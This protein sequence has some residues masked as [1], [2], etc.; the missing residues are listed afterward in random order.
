[1]PALG[2][3]CIWTLEIVVTI[4]VRLV[5]W[6]AIGA[7]AGV[8]LFYRGFRMLQFKRLVLN[9]PF[10]KIRSASMGLVEVSGMAVGP[11]TIQAGITGTPC[12]YYCATAWELKQ[13]GNNR[14]WK[15]V[16]E[17]TL[18]V[19]FFVDDSTGRLLVNPQGADLDVHRTFRDEFSTSAFGSRDMFP[20]NVLQFLARNGVGGSAS[21]RL[22]EHCI[23]PGY[24][25]FILGT[26]A[27]NRD[28]A[29][30]V[31]AP[32][33][34]VASSSIRSRSGFSF[35][36]AGGFSQAIIGSPSTVFGGAGTQIPMPSTAVA[37]A[38]RTAASAKVAAGNWSAVSMDDVAFAARSAQTRAPAS[39][40]AVPA[41][42]AA[43]AVA[44]RS[45]PTPGP[46][47]R[48]AAAMPTDD[49]GFPT[50]PPVVLA[51][52]LAHD[53]FA[54]SSES[55]RDIVRALAWKSSLFIWGG[56][57]LTL[58]CVYVLYQVL[59]LR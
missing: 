53:P 9:T 15:K 27:E 12:Y 51:K 3:F 24:P 6:A 23:E 8:V 37:T 39:P 41:A 58:I 52:G 21:V 49:A 2:S 42:Q 35:S 29:I 34:T 56:P 20:E 17:E 46:A 47:Q 11:H 1:M 40:I 59:G 43:T 26:L 30:G 38:G 50:H 55:Q 57:L 36:F 45:D 16:A 10:S 31:P 48:P 28:R 54:I 22:E 14:Q 25:L 44:E 32:H 19:P 7:V 33:M 18:Y 4:D 5:A 13:S